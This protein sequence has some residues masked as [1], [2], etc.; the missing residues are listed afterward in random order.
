VSAPATQA[1]TVWSFTFSTSTDELAANPTP[2]TDDSVRLDAA[3]PYAAVARL[4]ARLNTTDGLDVYVALMAIAP[5]S[6]VYV[7]DAGNHSIYVTL[8]TTGSP[9]D[10][11]TYVEIPVAYVANGGALGNK[12]AIAFAAIAPAGEAPPPDTGL[13]LV[14]LDEVKTHLLITTP[15]DDPGDADLTTKRDHAQSL[16]LSYCNSTAHWRSITATWTADTVPNE[17]KAAILLEVGELYRFRGDD[18]AYAEAI[19]DGFDLAPRVRAL[20]R[21]SRDPVI[22]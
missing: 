11:T 2:P 1:A 8:T 4:W 18:V 3:A 15:D 17:V 13:E 7:Q 9:I 21:R 5:G 16:V 12:K 19:S 22:A 10:K 6:T 14:S 20:L